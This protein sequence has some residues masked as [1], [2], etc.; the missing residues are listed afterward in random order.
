[1]FLV[2]SQLLMKGR[3]RVVLKAS[4]FPDIDFKFLT[5]LRPQPGMN[6]KPEGA[7][8]ELLQSTHRRTQYWPVKLRRQ[9]G[10]EALVKVRET[11]ITK[12]ID[13]GCN[14]RQFCEHGQDG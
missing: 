11:E 8:G 5:F 3:Q 13:D 7:S 10:G 9:L 2:R 1:M 6:K 4:L 14:T 12:A